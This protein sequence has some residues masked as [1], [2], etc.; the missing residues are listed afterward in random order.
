[1][2][3][4]DKIFLGKQE[5]HNRYITGFILGYDLLIVMNLEVM[6]I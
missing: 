6:L 2:E 4:L 1:M 5:M 3:V